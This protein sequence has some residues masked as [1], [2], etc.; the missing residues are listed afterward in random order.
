MSYLPFSEERL[1]MSSVC[2][3][4][5][6]THLSAPPIDV[7]GVASSIAGERHNGNV[8]L[9]AVFCGRAEAGVAHRGRRNFRPAFR[10]CPFDRG[11][12]FVCGGPTTTSRRSGLRL[13][14]AN[15]CDPFDE[16]VFLRLGEIGV[17]AHF[18]KS[19]ALAVVTIAAMILPSL[20]GWHYREVLAR[21]TM[22]TSPNEVCNRCAI[23]PSSVQ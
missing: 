21:S 8:D 16:V 17:A 5:R 7:V 1:A 23:S 15:C 19:V 20:A 9:T 2:I 12:L 18:E 6:K 10:R 4:G 22:V 13:G 3:H 11:R 14:V